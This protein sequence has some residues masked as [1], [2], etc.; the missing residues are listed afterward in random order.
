MDAWR[1]VL[2]GDR[3]V[4]YTKFLGWSVIVHEVSSHLAL[5][6]NIPVASSDINDPTIAIEDAFAKQLVVD[7]RM[8]YVQFIDT[9]GQEQ[10]TDLLEQPVRHN[11]G[12]VLVYSIA[13]RSTFE[14]LEIFRR[15][16]RR[17][18]GSN[19]IVMLVGNKCDRTDEREVST[20]EGAALARQFGCEFIET[21]AKTA[22]DVEHRG[23]CVV[24]VVE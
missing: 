17:V 18:N 20:E 3:G 4:V 21:S 23:T 8:C 19:P 10:H 2:L 24:H 5:T 6:V 1:I 7:N 12:F 13:S 9:A 16:I 14:R 15:L 11:E 22:Q